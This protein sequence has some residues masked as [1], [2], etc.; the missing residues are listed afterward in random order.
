MGDL[1]MAEVAHSR[2]MAVCYP[3]HAEAYK[4]MRSVLTHAGVSEKQL[5]SWM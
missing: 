4:V 1:E 3:N 5:H 2:Q